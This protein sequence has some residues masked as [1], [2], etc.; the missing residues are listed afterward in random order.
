[1]A[2]TTRGSPR[3]PGPLR[4]A[5]GF[6]A[7]LTAAVL[8]SPAAHAQAP[9]GGLFIT[10]AN[11]LTEI[12]AI[13]AK[14][15]RNLQRTDPPIRKIVFDFNPDNRPNTSDDY[16]VCR[17]LAG[18]ILEQQ[19]VTTVAFVHGDV[20]GHLV[21]PVLACQ[22][23]V[24]AREARLGDA[25]RGEAGKALAPDQRQFYLLVAE[26]R[27]RCPALVLKMLDKDMDVLEG[28]R[29]LAVWYIDARQ[30]R[31]EAEKGFVVTRR[32]PVVAAGAPALYSAAQAEK[33]SLCQLISESR[34]E[35]ATAY[36]MP[37]ASLREDPLE[38][39]TPVARRYIVRGEV[40][41]GQV[42][43]LIRS[44]R[45]QVANRANFIILQLECGGGSTQ[46]ARDLADFLRDLK[47]D[48][49]DSNAEVPVKTV[50]YIP[51]RAPDTATFIAL[52]C[53]EIVMGPQAE[54]GDF[55]NVV[56]RGRGG[57]RRE[58]DPGE[59]KMMRDSLVGL[60]KAQGYPPL[61]FQGMLDKN[62]TLYRVSSLK[63]V[64]EWRLLTEEEW[65]ADQAGEKKWGKRELI[66]AGGPDGKFLK[67]PA[68][69][70]KDLGV[71]HDLVAD[72]PNLYKHYELKGNVRDVGPDWLDAFASFLRLPVVAVF[73]VMVGITCLILELKMP[74]VG[75]PG[76]IAALCF[77]LYFWAQSQLAGQITMLAVL[78]FVLGLILIALEIF[79]LPGF[80][81]TGISGILLVVVSLGL[82]TLE[83][84][85]ETTQEWLNFGKT[86]TTFGLALL[87]A[88]AMALLLA[89]YLPHIPYANRLML[90]PPTEEDEIT[91][92][93]EA[94]GGGV[95]VSPALAALLGAIGVAVTPLRPAGMARFGEEFV[96][97][98]AEG[99]FV[100]AGNRVQV[101]EIEGNRVVVKEV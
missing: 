84:K 54:L 65:E 55:E 24:M 23:I 49:K 76:V 21:L 85:P 30:E 61:L 95:G 16:G 26:R 80:G 67:V 70:A 56:Y 90:K 62:L 32:E 41:K 44:I 11:P 71:A 87:G 60:A 12:G 75:L 8:T 20:T 33:F 69:L 94:A 29:K 79:V 99:S 28:R 42:E 63:G 92:P 22:E 83:K 35:V 101:I 74:G 13:K 31:A 57:A 88:V 68:T 100:P 52:G 14:V 18:F 97:V 1:M 36:Q 7:V 3:R 82:V 89:W 53:T 17:N 25:L 78:L 77:V 39:R 93:D 40:T 96:D 46:A 37:G 58:L 43:S 66:K 4:T 38:G 9:E 51:E 72:V 10:V 73:L 27:G 98:V 45:T 91:D 19:E 15:G 86:L 5:L 81:V 34:Q 48:L 50:A 47:C 59:Y 6:A 64:R 2:A